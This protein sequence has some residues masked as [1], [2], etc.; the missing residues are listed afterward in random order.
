[1]RTA[2]ALMSIFSLCQTRGQES[3][4]P[5][6]AMAFA[7][8]NAI[9]ISVTYAGDK[10]SGLDEERLRVKVFLALKN[11][12][13]GLRIVDSCGDKLALL[14]QCREMQLSG[15]KGQTFYFVT[16]VYELM[17][18]ALL[19]IVGGYYGDWQPTWYAS[20]WTRIAQSWGEHS[21][22]VGSTEKQIKDVIESLAYDYLRAKDELEKN[23]T[24]R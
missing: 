6:D 15:G 2:I 17:R 9:Q 4:S 24:H 7:D 1:M 8:L 18:P 10:I 11:D 12:V 21:D 13:P 22:V 14:V 3:I 16:T 19:Q 20:V 23:R 5:Y